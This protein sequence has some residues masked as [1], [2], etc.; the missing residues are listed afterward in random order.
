MTKLLS[1][2]AV[3]G[4]K[5]DGYH[6]PIDVLSADET[7]GLRRKLE[8]HER[9][10]GGPIQGDKRHK[11][12]LYLTWLNDLIRSPKILDAVEDVLGPNLFCWSIGTQRIVPIFPVH[13]ACRT[14]PLSVCRWFFWPRR[15]KYR[16]H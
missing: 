12:H 6:F 8:A 2:E 9:A 15:R 11:A 10:S 16:S 5:R 3:A 7:L 14:H 13:V 4:Y 1:D